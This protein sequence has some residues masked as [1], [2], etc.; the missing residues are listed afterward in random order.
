MAGKAG[1]RLV[2]FGAGNLAGLLQGVA[3]PYTTDAPKDIQVI[4]AGWDPQRQ[5]LTLVCQSESWVENTA[6]GAPLD[7]WSPSMQELLG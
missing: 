7:Q 2:H 5:V 6:E 3:K 1:R 4:G